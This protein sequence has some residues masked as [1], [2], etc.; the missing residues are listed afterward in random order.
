MM[1]TKNLQFL[2]F[3]VTPAWYKSE[4]LC[5]TWSICSFEVLTNTVILRRYTFASCLFTMNS[6]TSV[7]FCNVS[8]TICSPKGMRIEWYNPWWNMNAVLMQ[9]VS[10]I[11]NFQYSLLISVLGN[12]VTSS[13]ATMHSFIRGMGYRSLFCLCF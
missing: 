10:S 1:S 12:E 9:L 13:E 11:L 4:N 7:V 2:S 3:S 8:G 6:T 5:L